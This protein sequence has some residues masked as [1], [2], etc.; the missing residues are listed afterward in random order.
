YLNINE[1]DV[2]ALEVDALEV[3]AGIDGVDLDDIGSEGPTVDD[4]DTGDLD[5]DGL[6]LEIELDDDTEI[7]GP[8]VD[9][10]GAGELDTDALDTEIDLDDDLE[11]G[12]PSVDALETIDIPDLEDLNNLDLD[13]EL[14]SE[15]PDLD[16]IEIEINGP[17]EI[18]VE[19]ER[20]SIDVAVPGKRSQ[21][22]GITIFEDITLTPSGIPAP[23]T[24]RGISGGPLTASQVAGRAQTATGICAGFVDA[25]PDHR[26]ELTDF[27]DYL[28][29]QVESPEDTVLVVRGPGGSWC[30]D[31]VIGTNPG[32]AG[33][34]FSG[35]YDIWVGSYNADTYHPYVIRLTETE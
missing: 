3:D 16:S 34:W 22:G 19:V 1:P 31:D 5:T 21:F 33:E 29:L 30:N 28:S 11:L 27:F 6:D 7:E 24:I 12:E 18:E 13:I 23:I 17:N 35:V 8:S 2:D 10:L 25:E 20:P 4:L 14:P 32:I 9:D 26:M 15:L